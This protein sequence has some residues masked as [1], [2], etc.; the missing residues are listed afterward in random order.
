MTILII[1]SNASDWKLSIPGV[2]VV[3]A[4]SYLT[5]PQFINRRNARVFNLSRSYRYQSTGYYVSLLAAA[6]GHK[7]IPGIAAIQDMKSPAV[8]RI[9]SYEL[10]ELI[11]KSLSD[12]KSRDYTLSIYFGRNLSPKYNK[13]SLQLFNL[14]QAPLLR[15]HFHH[16]G[17]IWNLKSI[18]PIAA[19][20]IPPD[21]QTYVE[22]FARDYFSGK[23]V[24]APKRETGGY[25][26]AILVN[27]KEVAAP[28]DPK[29]IEKF[30]RA[31]EKTGISAEAITRD[32]YARLAEY[33]ALFIRETTA[34]NHHTFRFAQRAQAE[35]LA[36]VDDPESIIRCTNKVY[37]AELLEMH[38]IPAPRTM[39][40]HRDNKRRV[41]EE[42]GFPMVL[43]K[44]DSS[45]SQGVAKVND[46]AAFQQKIDELFDKSDLLIAQ[47]FLPTDFDWRVG[48]FNRQPLY[49][50]KYYMAK[51]HWQI[52]NWET[53]GQKRFGKVETLP[54]E[55]APRGLIRTALT[56]ANLIGDGLYGVDLK[57]I[58]SRFIV[59]EV[60]DNPSIETGVEDEVLRDKLYLTMME[61]FL[62]MIK[63]T[64]EIQ[65]RQD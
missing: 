14:F 28:S 22:E 46:E 61:I 35:G 2:E 41:M 54:V 32:D 9:I 18:G 52:M 59:I 60:N 11:Q 50:C 15:A 63:K 21:H 29:T 5:D 31:A 36:V 33:D 30:I 62:K 57:Q 49:V 26:M 20:E 39:V 3:S 34:V 64:K 44:P 42:L 38:R 17:E 55:L 37:L 24:R 45:F 43:K 1:V 12:L 47:E 8:V 4:R 65:S 51:K 16:D 53:T 23:R 58:D 10:E 48:I 25:D 19:N 40:V 13:L 7:A 6:R 56:T 27:P